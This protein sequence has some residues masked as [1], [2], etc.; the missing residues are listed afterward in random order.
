[1]KKTERI[2]NLALTGL[3]IL[4]HA[5]VDT[6][7]EKPSSYSVIHKEFFQHSSRM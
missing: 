4:F 1:M 2:A 5:P 3:F 6:L 7:I